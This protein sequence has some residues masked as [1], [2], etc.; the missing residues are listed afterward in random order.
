MRTLVILLIPALFVLQSNSLKAQSDDPQNMQVVVNQEPHYPA[1]DAALYQLIYNKL[2]FPEKPKGTLIN[3]QVILYFDVMPDSTLQNFVVMQGV[4]DNID[5]QIIN[6][7]KPLKFV[8]S[9]QNNTAV[10][11]N[12]MYT[13]P[14]TKR[15]N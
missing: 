10:K 4:E 3:S 5:N 15:Y 6:I 2:V 14:V 13:I 9:V 12:V 7:M 1:G 11:M 8:P